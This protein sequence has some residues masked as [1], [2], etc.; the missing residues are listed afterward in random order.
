MHA[1]DERVVPHSSS[2]SNY[3]GA[4]DNLLS[5]VPI[6]ASQVHAILENVPVAQ[7]ATQYEGQLI[8]TPASVLPRNAQGFPVFDMMLLGMG[9]DGHVASLFPHRK[10]VAETVRWVLPIE[11]SPKPPSERIT[12]TLPVRNAG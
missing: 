2:E 10:A 3:K 12:F 8:S 11:N 6:P 7:A 4:F 1:Q 5:K 9:P